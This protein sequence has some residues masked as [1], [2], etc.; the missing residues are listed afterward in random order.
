MEG[1]DEAM[2]EPSTQSLTLDIIDYPGRRPEAYIADLNLESEGLGTHHLLAHHRQADVTAAA[3]A[4]ALFAKRPQE[5]G[6]VTAV[7]GYCAS[8]GVSAHYAEIVAR[9][10]GQMPLLICFDASPC[11]IG[12]IEDCYLTA[13]QQIEE[14]NPG[15]AFPP[16]SVPALV[17]RPHLLIHAV[18]EDL[19]RRMVRALAADGL[20]DDDVAGLVTQTVDDTHISWITHLLACGDARP[21]TRMGRTLNVVSRGYTDGPDW[22]RGED[23]LTVRIDCD[24]ADLLRHPETRSAVLGFVREGSVNA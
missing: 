7:L 5:D 3:Y 4:E 22:L 1:L 20:T 2:A 17:D 18:R 10:T 19:T 9:E 23:V 11:T 6:G 8:S 16:V 24:R 12:D 15:T 13:L 21:S 14:D